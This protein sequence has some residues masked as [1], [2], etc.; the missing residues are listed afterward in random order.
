LCKVLGEKRRKFRDRAARE[1]VTNLFALHR[2]SCMGERMTYYDR[3]LEAQMNSHMFL[4]TIADGMMQNH[5]LL[6]WFGNTKMPGSM[7]VKQH[8]QGV[9][10]H[11]HN[12]TIYRTFANISGGANLSIH[13]W[14]LSLECYYANHGDL[15]PTIY[16][17]IDGGPENANAEFTAVAALLVASG[18]VEKVVLTRLPVGHTHEGID[19]LFALIWRALRLEFVLTPTEFAKAVCHALRK[20]STVKVI[21]IFCVPDYVKILDKCIDPNLSRMFKEEWTQLQIT[22]ESDVHSHLGVK[23]SY[24]AY[25][26]DEFVEIVEEESFP[27]PNATSYSGIIP[28]LARVKT[29]PLPG[30]PV[31]K[32][33]TAMPSGDFLPAPFVEG[34]RAQM[35]MTANYMITSYSSSRPEISN[36]WQE[37]ISSKV[38]FS[39][40]AQDYISSGKCGVIP[41]DESDTRYDLQG[42]RF[43]CPF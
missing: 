4:S 27:G 31:L 19:G 16:H 36:E 38:P 41:V 15:P 6:P 28:Q 26:Q 5:C 14:L 8:L 32:V 12:I 20:K 33:P 1:E 25:V 18:L 3:R 37:W 42:G 22:F 7:H 10:M 9:Y 23:C 29:H 39:D 40:N 43:V 17:Q 30:E 21:D 24:R 34:S 35:E 2:M 13:T 11:G